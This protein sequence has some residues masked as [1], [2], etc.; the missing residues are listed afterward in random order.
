MRGLTETNRQPF[1]IAG[2]WGMKRIWDRLKAYPFL[3]QIRFY[4]ILETFLK[5]NRKIGVVG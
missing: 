5:Q 2:K 4:N 1:Q 3:L